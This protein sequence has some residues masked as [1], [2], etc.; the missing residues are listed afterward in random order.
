MASRCAAPSG[1]PYCLVYLIFSTLPYCI[2]SLHRIQVQ[3]FGAV[4][5]SSMPTDGKLTSCECGRNEREFHH[6]TRSSGFKIT[7]STSSFE[8]T[9]HYSPKSVYLE[10]YMVLFLQSAFVPIGR[11]S[12][13]ELL[14][15]LRARSPSMDRFR[16]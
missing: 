12:L 3:W 10:T 7:H 16:P 15:K 5:N 11:R 2:S 6:C 9:R 13:Y 4:D 8:L 1:C 14:G